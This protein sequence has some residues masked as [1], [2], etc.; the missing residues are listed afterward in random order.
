MVNTFLGAMCLSG[1][2]YTM[3]G[4]QWALVDRDI[5]F[6][7]RVRHLIAHGDSRVRQAGVTSWSDPKGY[8]WVIRENG[9]EALVTLHAFGGDLPKA[10]AVPVGDGEILDL[11]TSEGNAAA[12]SGGNLVVEVKANFEASAFHIR[13]KP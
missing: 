3:N 5:A 6:Y 11:V 13:K 4:E 8:Q 2:I 9:S 7:R 1:D 12:I 10:V